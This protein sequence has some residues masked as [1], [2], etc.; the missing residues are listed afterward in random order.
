MVHRRDID[1]SG[2]WRAA[3]AA[4]ER[5]RRQYVDDD[6][7]D[8]EWVPV[9]VPGHWR[10]SAALA[11]EDGP[12]LYRTRF[13]ADGGT[14]A[15]G[16]A[17]LVFD[18]VLAASD[19]WLDGT[20]LGDTSGYVAAHAFEVTDLLRR[21][22]EHLLAMEVSN[23]PV[24]PGRTRDLTGS[25]GRSA[26]TGEHHNVGGVW[27]PVGI[28]RTGPVRLRYSRLRCPDATT[29]RASVAI[30]AVLDTVEARTVTLRTSV[31]PVVDAQGS[32]L[33]IA[34]DAPLVV[35]REH[36]LAAGENRV[37]WT[38]S[39]PTPELWWP[40]ALGGQPLYDVTVDV[41][42]DDGPS[43]SR[44][45]R[46]G[47]RQVRMDDFVCRINDERLFL[48]GLS[49]GPT[50]LLLAE[51]SGHEV[52]ADV[53]RAAA[54]GLDLLRVHGHV[55]RPELYE[56]ADRTGMLL[57]QDLPIQWGMQRG[58]KEPARQLARASV[59]RLAHHPSIAIWCTH[60]EP[61]VGD[62]ASQRVVR[63]WARPRRRAAVVATHLLPTWNRTVLDR[64]V[65]LVLDRSDGSRPVVA[66]A[67]VWP[68][69]PQ[70]SGTSTH[71][72]A[73]WRWG[74][75]DS[76][77]RLLRAWPR[78]ARFVGEFGA[79]SPGMDPGLL[80]PRPDQERNA[81][82]DPS[83][84]GRPTGTSSAWPA[85]DWAAIARRT[86]LE[87]DA[88]SRVASPASHRNAND[89]ADALHR[90]QAELVRSHIETLRRL[91]Y[92]PSGGFTAFAM[93]DP[94]PG[95]T[96]ALLD[97]ERR[98]KPAWAALIE[99]CAPLIAISDRPPDVLRV[100]EHH[101]L[102]VHVVNDR[103]VPLGELVVRATVSWGTDDSPRV[104]PPAPPR[105]D[106]RR[107][108][109]QG[110]VGA[111]AVVRVGSIHLAVPPGAESLVLE[112]ELSDAAG[113]LSRRR[114]QRQVA[115]T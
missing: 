23:G 102:D 52:E 65:S 83:R 10:S 1:L 19:V 18:G 30:R 60:H 7:D 75:I 109:W 3:P 86:G 113:V 28:V 13:V 36:P 95:I 105:P 33:E 51:A 93:A 90:H 71:L 55:G 67:G 110:E 46:T 78:L 44:T 16:R 20:Y 54:A 5:L 31:R 77:P 38:V 58:A 79:Q 89:W 101:D 25:L 74:T 2:T 35:E 115:D 26:L 34:G 49:I 40:R 82:H 66:H 103:R 87:V 8:T 111:D 45:W 72:W 91:K 57:W 69:L 29:Q 39:V 104:V 11:D 108:A 59:D 27:R 76:L 50:R 70:L 100:G 64:S 68:H 84:P 22:P 24:G 41:I 112:L 9:T 21:R 56:A 61:W 15:D 53:E 32:M 88:A 81:H 97:H 114:H 4:D 107:Q 85:L 99:A 96:A 42:V 48:K 47:L 12:V 43:D 94:A 6:L 80:D 17:F 98:P 92:R 73:G 63:R 14:D 62:P 106:I 37:E